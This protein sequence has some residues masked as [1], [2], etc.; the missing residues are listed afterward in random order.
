[1]SKAKVT[2][3]NASGTPSS[4]TFLRGDGSWNTPSGSTVIRQPDNFGTKTRTAAGTNYS[5]GIWFGNL[6]TVVADG[7][8][9][10]VGYQ[11]EGAK[12]GINA[13]PAVYTDNAG[14]P[15]TLL[16]TG[17]QVNNAVAGENVLPLTSSLTVTAG[18]VL[19]I[20]AYQANLGSIGPSI[21]TGAVSRYWIGSPPAPATAPATTAWGDHV[22]FYGIGYSNITIYYDAPKDGIQ[23]GRKNDLWTPINAAA[24]SALIA[25]ASVPTVTTS[26][27]AG[28]VWFGNRVYVAEAMTINSVAF[29]LN[30]TAT[31]INGTPAIYADSSAT[32]AGALLASGPTVANATVGENI[33]PLTTPLVVAAGTWLW[34]GCYQANIGSITGN[35][36]ARTTVSYYFISSPP[37]ASTAGAL[38]AWSA[39]MAI[40]GIGTKSFVPNASYVIPFGF[41][42]AP[43][44]SETLLIHAFADSVVLPDEFENSIWIVGTAP[45][46]SF[47]ID[48]QKYTRSTATWASIGTI[49]IATTGVVTFTTSGVSVS[50][51]P[52][53]GLRVIAQAGV[54]ATLANVAISFKGSRS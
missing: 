34:I 19:W 17:P 4:A 25:G 41:T 35:T 1:M 37:P 31:G 9:D 51:I 26:G 20:G 8:I 32:A 12:T 38:T 45:T 28:G 21:G 48:V 53:D 5:G 47:V 36:V 49:T 14:V 44:A 18:Q 15:G 30:A 54:D 2:D 40:Y 11:I 33:L 27:Y 39:S 24:T 52:G 16:A 29:K 50:F 3:I 46:S 22:L 23:Y 13:V 43:A 7:Q 6:F 42:S 10:S